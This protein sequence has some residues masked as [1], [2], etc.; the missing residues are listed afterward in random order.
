MLAAILFEKQ[1]VLTVLVA[2][3]S[4]DSH[5]AL[6]A[7]SYRTVVATESAFLTPRKLCILLVRVC[8]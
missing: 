2:C 7:K 6:A 1:F 8:K 3:I 4:Y 5:S